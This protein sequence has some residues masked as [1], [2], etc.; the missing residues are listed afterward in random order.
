MT[1]LTVPLD[2][3]YPDPT[4]PADLA[5]RAQREGRRMRTRRRSGAAVGTAVAVGA[6]AALSSGVAGP[7]TVGHKP[8]S[9]A[10]AGRAGGPRTAGGLAVSTGQGPD[11]QSFAAAGY[12]VGIPPARGGVL[13]TV[14]VINTA[15]AGTQT[16]IYGTKNANLCLGTR[17][18]TGA[19]VQAAACQHLSGLPAQGFWGG[20]TSNLSSEKPHAN[21]AAIVSG[22]VRGPVSR[23]VVRTPRGDIDATLAPA[24]TPGLGTLYWAVTTIPIADN[25]QVSQIT[26][27]AY[28]GAVP[29]FAC[30]QAQCDRG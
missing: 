21:D 25:R 27:V 17:A 23:V 22:L 1:E 28:R 12:R 9:T 3:A 7:A 11:A 8:S 24:S 6:A 19:E 18:R 15:H 30:T 13:G 20:G 4:P 26:R 2:L 10:A 16:V 5:E 29:I 14:H